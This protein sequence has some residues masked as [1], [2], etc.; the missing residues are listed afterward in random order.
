MQGAAEVK[1]ILIVD[2]SAAIRQSLR[3][4]LETYGWIVE[5]AANGLE[6]LNQLEHVL[7]HL[8]IL[9]L[10]MPIMNGLQAAPK[11]KARLPSVPLIMF[12]NH[13][14]GVLAQEAADAGV[15]FL[16]DK[17]LGVQALVDIIAQRLDPDQSLARRA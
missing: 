4:L 11:L 10:S 16:A 9:D 6:A 8:V 15:D 3:A 1:V 2:D 7:P 14:S 12:T 13:A 5:E 17:A